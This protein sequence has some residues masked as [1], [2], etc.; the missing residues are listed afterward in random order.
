MNSPKPLPVMVIRLP[1]SAV[2]GESEATFGATSVNR[3]ASTEANPRSAQHDPSGF[4]VPAPRR[5][6][7]GPLFALMGTHT[8]MTRSVHWKIRPGTPPKRTWLG[9]PS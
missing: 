1:I 5:T 3:P 6:T 4:A 9:P 2:S 8:S 7:S